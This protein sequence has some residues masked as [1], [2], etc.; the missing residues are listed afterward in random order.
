[1]SRGKQQYKKQNTREDILFAVLK[2]MDKRGYRFTYSLSTKQVKNVALSK[3]IK[4]DGQFPESKRHRV[5]YTKENAI[6]LVDIICNMLLRKYMKFNFAEC[7]QP[8][9]KE[10]ASFIT[11]EAPLEEVDIKKAIAESKAEAKSL[12]VG[13]NVEL[14]LLLHEG[15]RIFIRV[16][17]ILEKTLGGE[18]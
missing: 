3:G 15:V 11:D 17:Q 7:S 4:A 2:E 6:K 12:S 8:V 9:Y 14:A 5:W 13:D 10:H 16:A 1:M 18:I